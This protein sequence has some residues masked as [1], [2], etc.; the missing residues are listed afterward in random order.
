MGIDPSTRNMGVTVIDVDLGVSKPFELKYGNTIYGD[1][2]LFDI[3]PQYD[4]TDDTG[5]SARSFGLA[6]SLGTLLELY[7]PDWVICEDNYL[8]HSPGTFKQLITFVCM[9][10]EQC[11]LNGTHVSYVLPNLA[12]AIVG[13]NFKGSEKADVREG[14]LK[15]S[16]LTPGDVAIDLLD[17]H[18]V[19]AGA[20]GL[21][22]AEQL[23]KRYGVYPDEGVP[24]RA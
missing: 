5:V 22:G 21:W 23:A 8:Q 16:W 13:A 18:S 10:T 24:K 9:V 15:Y 6:R 2:C 3:P 4:D 7:K 14:L 20:V 17:E 1:K 19:D 12:K 11:K